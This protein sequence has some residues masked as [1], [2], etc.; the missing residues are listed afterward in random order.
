MLT[1]IVTA[2]D[3]F[4]CLY[5]YYA[6]FPSLSDKCDLLAGNCS[7]SSVEPAWARVAQTHP[8]VA[9]DTKVVAADSGVSLD[10]DS[11]ADSG[12]SFR[13]SCRSGGLPGNNRRHRKGRGLDDGRRRKQGPRRTRTGWG[14]EEETR[15][16]AN[17]FGLPW[18]CS[19]H[20]GH[21]SYWP[22]QPSCA[23]FSRPSMLIDN[24]WSLPE[25]YKDRFSDLGKS[26]WTRPSFEEETIHPD[27]RSVGQRNSD[28]QDHTDIQ[29]VEQAR[30]ISPQCGSMSVS[31]GVCAAS[32][33]HTQLMGSGVA[34]IDTSLENDTDLLVVESSAKSHSLISTKNE[35]SQQIV[36]ADRL[37]A[38]LGNLLSP[39]DVCLSVLQNGGFGVTLDTDPHPTGVNIAVDD[40]DL[41]LG[42]RPF[43][44][45]LWDVLN[46]ARMWCG[47]PSFSR[48]LYLAPRSSDRDDTYD[49]GLHLVE[50]DSSSLCNWSDVESVI[51]GSGCF[52]LN[53]NFS[54]LSLQDRRCNNAEM[55]PNSD[56]LPT[57]KMLSS[58]S[59]DRLTCTEILGNEEIWDGS[60]IAE[61]VLENDAV[62][63]VLDAEVLQQIWQP[64]SY[65]SID[66]V[67]SS[68]CKEDSLYDDT[69]CRQ[70]SVPH[71]TE[72]RIAAAACLVENNVD[73]HCR[74]QFTDWTNKCHCVRCIWQS[75]LLSG[76]A[77]LSPSYSSTIT[78]HESNPHIDVHNRER[79]VPP[80]PSSASESSIFWNELNE[81]N[82]SII[83]ASSTWDSQLFFA[84]C[85]EPLSL[86]HTSSSDELNNT[87]NVYEEVTKSSTLV[88]SAG[89][90]DDL[91]VKKTGRRFSF[92]QSNKDEPME[93][94]LGGVS[95]KYS[96]SDNLD[97]NDSRLD[98]DAN[99]NGQQHIDDSLCTAD[100]AGK[101]SLAETSETRQFL[102]PSATESELCKS[103]AATANEASTADVL[104]SD[105]DACFAS[106]PVSLV[107]AS[108]LEENINNSSGFSNA[109]D[110]ACCGD[111]C[112]LYTSDAADE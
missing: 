95:G 79:T 35:Q 29:Y 68:S 26:Q 100:V 109:V 59:V 90:S 62:V 72:D 11:S 39:H 101:I 85:L 75:E 93:P 23:G 67:G 34:S 1:L 24:D 5:R 97:H 66:K 6:A 45:A 17:M 87:E 13:G 65:S 58:N 63:M 18:L 111:C 74:S 81:D 30:N 64:A 61:A 96:I 53:D 9:S 22:L 112:L 106:Y 76:D 105:C 36:V 42:C 104:S 20:D 69:I 77:S 37:P 103:A 32:R 73:W 86:D 99:V 83:K 50:V 8:K 47:N 51:E 46:S 92:P 48:E 94:V 21:M 12:R 4:V 7:S 110:I 33:S 88:K 56:N 82:H 52:D 27:E 19:G 44:P 28:N 25:S 78:R 38:D 108:L 55:S 71:S 15:W 10:C 16:P 107:F 2:G 91:F 40:G 80:L 60:H 70:H 54:L 102:N 43:D 98:P 89:S 14:S 57:G 84:D 41:F 31:G 3:V 49:V